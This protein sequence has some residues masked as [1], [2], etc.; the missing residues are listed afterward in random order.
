MTLHKL[1]WDD[2]YLAR[3]VACVVTVDGEHVTLDRTIAYAFSGGQAS[4][5]GTIAGRD[6][7][8]AEKSGRDIV[9]TLPPAH[10][11]QAGDEVEIV[12][13][14]ERRYR[15]MRLHFAA[16]L[17]LELVTRHFDA[18]LKLGANIGPDKAR[19]DFVWEGSIA[20]TFP[21]LSSEVSRLVASN[22]P[23]TSAF[24]D[25]SA[26]RRYWEIDGFARVPCGG[27]HPRSTAEVGEIALRR[28]N[29]G[30]GKERI[31]IR[32]LDG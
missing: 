13:D 30:K 10:G 8:H 3:A 29:I 6:I 26:E 4:D 19:L 17:V 31:E 15:I 18:P 32:L 20:E 22:L 9:Y 11:L 14:W 16:E 27:T 1:F 21:L 25:E 2:P 24:A 7:L 23:I 28:D 5:T 12:I